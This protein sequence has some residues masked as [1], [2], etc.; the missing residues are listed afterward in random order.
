MKKSARSLRLAHYCMVGALTLAVVIVVV[1]PLWA[2]ASFDQNREQEETTSRQ[3]EPADATPSRDAPAHHPGMIATAGTS[4][5]MDVYNPEMDN[6]LQAPRLPIG[7][8]GRS[9]KDVEGIIKSLGGKPY[10]YA[11]GKYSRMTL[12]VYLVTLL[13]DRERRLGAVRID[14]RPPFV[15]V[16]GKARAFF[17]KMFLHQADLT[18]FHVVMAPEYLEIAYQSSL[19]VRDPQAASDSST[20]AAD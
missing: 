16:E 18:Q 17:L 11:F 15:Q 4:F 10:S 13:F 14:P 6:F 1:A 19:S 2:Q 7:L 12:S 8:F 20:K 3:L 9:V 5:R